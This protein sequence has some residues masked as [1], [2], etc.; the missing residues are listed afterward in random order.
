MN[1]PVEIHQVHLRPSDFFNANPALDVPGSK[2]IASV[3][4]DG[5]DSCCKKSGDVQHAPESHLQGTGP[6]L[7][8][9]S[10]L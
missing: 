7:D 1:R 9:K 4:V 6:D 2:N 3:F 5:E 8:P 10:K